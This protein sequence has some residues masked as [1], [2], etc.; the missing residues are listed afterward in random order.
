MKIIWLGHASFHIISS[1]KHIYIDPFQLTPGMDKADLILLTHTHHDHTSPSDILLVKKDETVFVGT[2]DSPLVEEVTYMAPGEKT[3]VAGVSIEA[4]PAY[5]LDKKF[6]TQDKG[7]NGYILNLEGKRVYHT[8]DTDFIPELL[9]VT[10]DVAFLPVSGTYVMT[11]EQA[12]TVAVQ[13][14]PKLVIPMHYGA[15]V[16]SKEDADEFAERCIKN[17][18]KVKVMSKNESVEF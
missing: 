15:I 8:G 6:H 3:V 4:V 9:K 14:K 13:L 2:A 7:W 16:G 5:N 18:L 12:A 10:C 1:G 11:A 17:G